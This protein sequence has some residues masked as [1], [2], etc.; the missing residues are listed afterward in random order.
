MR[1]QTIILYM[2]SV[3]MCVPAGSHRSPGAAAE[4]LHGV[5]LALFPRRAK[6]K[7]SN[8][9]RLEFDSNMSKS[10]RGRRLTLPAGYAGWISAFHCAWRKKELQKYGPQFGLKKVGGVGRRHFTYTCKGF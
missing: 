5:F 7:E 2:A 6:E 8:G 4:T 10:R 1:L 3:C 9:R